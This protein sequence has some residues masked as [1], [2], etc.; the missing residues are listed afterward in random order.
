M[1]AK[2]STPS[3]PTFGLTYQAKNPKVQASINALQSLL[4]SVQNFTCDFSPM[5]IKQI[6][7][8]MKELR[9]D[10]KII[11]KANVST[12]IE[13]VVEGSMNWEDTIKLG[14][15]ANKVNAIK[16]QLTNLMNVLAN[17]GTVNGNV[18]LD[19]LVKHLIDI[20]NSI[21]PNPVDISK[22]Y[23]SSRKST[24]GYSSSNTLLIIIVIV[25]AIFLLKKRK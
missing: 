11:P 21:C 4:S 23:S 3:G 16:T 14:F 1:G 22:I 20:L 19:T 18:N 7:D 5:L 13:S 8:Q 9:A 12:V 24:F 17:N 15:P 10:Q 6:Q 25:I 2:Q